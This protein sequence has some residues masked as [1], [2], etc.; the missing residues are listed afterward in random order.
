MYVLLSSLI[1]I[2]VCPIYI[3]AQRDSAFIGTPRYAPNAASATLS[4]E[5]LVNIDSSIAGLHLSTPQRGMSRQ[6]SENDQY[7]T[8]GTGLLQENGMPAIRE[9]QENEDALNDN[10]DYLMMQPYPTRLQQKIHQY[11]NV[12][13]E[14]QQQQ[15]TAVGMHR[16]EAPAYAISDAR[17]RIHSSESSSSN[18]PDL[19][20]PTHSLLDNTTCG[21]DA[22]K[23]PD[24][25]VP[26]PVT[27]QPVNG[28]QRFAQGIGVQSQFNFVSSAA[29][30]TSTVTTQNTEAIVPT[31]VQYMNYNIPRYNLSS[32]GSG[33]D[34]VPPG[35]QGEVGNAHARPRP[36]PLSVSYTGASGNGSNGKL[37]GKSVSF[38][39]GETNGTSQGKK[40]TPP[41]HRRASAGSPG[42]P[43]RRPHD[44]ELV[45][46]PPPD[47][48]TKHI[49]VRSPE[50]DKTQKLFSPD[51]D[52]QPLIGVAQSVT[53]MPVRKSSSADSKDVGPEPVPH[54]ESVLLAEFPDASQEM[55]QRA[56]EMHAYDIMKAKKEVMVQ[57]LLGMEIA[58]VDAIDCR[59]ALSHCQWKLDRAAAWLL[60][61]SE[62]ILSRIS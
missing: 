32:S 59:R 55:C 38:N 60:D 20:S 23:L 39:A 45:T 2:T 3:Q 10:Y 48:E 12:P 5:P 53:K 44:Y 16:E 31:S 15:L 6:L 18:T 7:V 40:G 11:Q 35:D 56:L 33:S 9:D 1:L 13:L 29:I 61:Q 58:C 4:S 42:K 24:P 28:Q 17:D 54:Y 41:L 27:N 34:L 19:T 43:I 37:W 26:T 49:G 14:G 47:W 62:N 22:A 52:Q 51:S 8:M 30:P 50:T 36:R 25:L 46:S 21:T 57:L